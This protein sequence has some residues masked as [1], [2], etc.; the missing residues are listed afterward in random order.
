MPNLSDLEKS[1]MSAISRTATVILGSQLKRHLSK[2]FTMSEMLIAVMALHVIMCS[3]RPVKGFYASWLVMCDLFQSVLVQLI[4]WNVSIGNRIEEVLMKI[5]FTLMIAEC[6]GSCIPTA[7]GW[8]SSDLHAF[9]T[10]VSFIFAGRVSDVINQ[11]GV[12]LVGAVLGL[13]STS[14]GR[15]R[16]VGGKGLIGATMTMAAINIITETIL[17]SV[18][19]GGQLALAWPLTLLYFVYQLSGK[20]ENAQAFF[21]YAVYTTSNIVYHGLLS[22]EITCFTVVVCLLM[23][24]FVSWKIITRDH[25]WTVLCSLVL[26]QA[27]SDWFMQTVHDVFATDPV[28][29]GLAVVTVIHFAAVAVDVWGKRRA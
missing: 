26:V 2:Y 16:L 20:Y 5:I 23:L 25:V 3:T 8:F 24:S 10:S 21:D 13:L 15:G 14:C 4:V 28:L 17:G 1:N 27:V 7:R 11:T 29:A 9:E 18:V 19:S 6:I 22:Y 12:P